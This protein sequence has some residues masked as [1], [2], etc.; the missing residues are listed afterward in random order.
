M[1]GKSLTSGTIC[2]LLKTYVEC[3]NF[4]LKDTNCT[5]DENLQEHMKFFLTQ[6]LKRHS[7]NCQNI[8]GYNETSPF[9]KGAPRAVSDVHR[10]AIE[11]SEYG[12]HGDQREEADSEHSRGC[13]IEDA[14]H[15]YFTCGS[16]FL[17]KMV[18]WKRHF[19]KHQDVYNLAG[20]ETSPTTP[21]MRMLARKANEDDEVCEAIKELKECTN[22]IVSHSEC[23][24]VDGLSTKM[25]SMQEMLDTVQACMFL[26]RYGFC[27]EQARKLTNCSMKVKELEDFVFLTNVVQDK[28]SSP[29]N[30]EDKSTLAE[31]KGTSAFICI[32]KFGY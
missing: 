18:I 9:S 17:W 11:S 30:P 5:S 28:Y 10:W 25:V 6:S 23:K 26:S 4:A 20:N 16:N 27:V 29:C 32:H 2:E 24:K 1:E 12:S 3:G 8:P 19:A 31:K 14:L 7:L 21:S 13:A 22:E 15:R